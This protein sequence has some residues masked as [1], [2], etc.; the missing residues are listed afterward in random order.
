MSETH[1]SRLEAERRAFAEELGQWFEDRGLP[2]MEGRVAGWLI[3]CDPPEQS[4]EDLAAV[5]GASRGAISMATRLLQRAGAVERVNQ[6]GSR[7]HYYRLRPGMW[8]QDIDKR[9]EEAVQVRE[10]AA[11][12]MAKLGEA[13]GGQL[14]RLRDM[15]QMYD[16]LAEEYTSIRDRWHRQEKGREA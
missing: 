10:L 14:D 4:A 6:P 13:P 1:E 7:K 12:G 15:Y 8:R 9:V 3:V 2:R 16:F 11:K 5:L